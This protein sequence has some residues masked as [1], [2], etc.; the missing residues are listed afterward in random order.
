MPAIAILFLFNVL[1]ADVSAQG[2][3]PEILKRMDTNSKSLTSLKSSVK[4][5]KANSQLGE[6]DLTEGDLSLIPGRT[7]R[8]IFLRID[9]RKPVVEHLAIA[10]GKYVLYKPST[11]QAITGSVDSVKGSGKSGGVLAFMTMNKTQLKENYD[12]KYAG[13]E[14]VSS[15]VNTFHLVLIPKKATSYKSA[16]L[17]VDT[18][19]MPIQAKIVEKNNDTTTLLLSNIQRNVTVKAAD[20]KISPAKGTKIVQ[21]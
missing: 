15:G 7:D 4:M 2:V 13:E 3:L 9:W 5:N 21:G 17:W 10:K 18:N 12:V 1:S 11:N 20:F 8:E 19:G 16:D 6:N 14:T